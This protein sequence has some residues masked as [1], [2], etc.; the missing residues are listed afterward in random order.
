MSVREDVIRALAE[1]GAQSIYAVRKR[2]GASYSACFMAVKSLEAEGLIRLK[3]MSLGL[4]RRAVKVYM[5]THEGLVEAV[6]AG[7]NGRGAE[8]LADLD[9]AV[10]GAW[11]KLTELVPEGEVHMALMHAARACYGLRGE[12][13]VKAFRE[14]FYTAP[15]TQIGF[16]RDAW[17][18]AI[19]SDPDLK[20]L[21]I[22]ILKDTLNRISLNI[23]LINEAIRMLEAD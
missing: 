3:E 10:F 19:K 6:R 4:G 15:F 18:R 23:R 21:V 13:A 8:R 14:A 9:P 22:N 20:Q 5:L 16:S 2:V 1:G 7:W 11:R 17:M 12:E